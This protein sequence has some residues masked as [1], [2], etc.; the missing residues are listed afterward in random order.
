VSFR[1]QTSAIA[2]S[3]V[4]SHPGGFFWLY[5]GRNTSFSSH[6]HNLLCQVTITSSDI[7]SH[8]HALDN[9]NTPVICIRYIGSWVK[10]QRHLVAGWAFFIDHGVLTIYTHLKTSPSY[11]QNWWGVNVKWDS[12]KLTLYDQFRNVFILF[13]ISSLISDASFLK[14]RILR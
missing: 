14:I 13:W 1:C 5:L 11:N 6:F 2:S 8:R 10:S 12:R 3:K 4:G 7:G 9:S